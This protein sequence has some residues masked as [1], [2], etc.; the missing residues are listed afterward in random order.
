ML[1]VG[2]GRSQ[3][4]IP[5]MAIDQ[6]YNQALSAMHGEAPRLAILLASPT[7]YDQT[8]L[9]MQMKLR[10]PD[11]AVVGCSTSGEI[12]HLGVADNSVVM[13][14]MGGDEELKFVTAR[15]ENMSEDAYAC[16]KQFAD[17][18]LQLG[19]SPPKAVLLFPDGLAG[20]GAQLMC[21]V[22]ETLGQD[23]L[24]AGGSAGDDF[25][26]KQTYQYLNN[27]LLTNSVVG[28]G[29]YGN[30]QF[31][32]GVRHGWMPIGIPRTVTKSKDNIVYELD[33]KPAI[34][35]YNDQFGEETIIIPGEPFAKLAITYPLGIE[36]DGHQEFLIRDPL[37]V[38]DEGGIKCA[39]EIQ[40][41]SQVYVMI[42]GAV[43][44]INAAELAAN[45]AKARLGNKTPKAAVLFNCIARK[46][47]LL[48][49]KHEELDK[50][51]FVLGDVP[52]IGFYTYGEQASTGFSEAVGCSF[53]NETDVIFLIAE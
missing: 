10:L 47:I 26:F 20:N 22:T 37:E 7:R 29:I 15:G 8:R 52:L 16:G 48:D 2:V 33:G 44:A 3:D 38:T 14:L 17:R 32:L 27:E 46:K 5:E 9:L 43:E 49:R 45:Q 34:E 19:E 1:E 24:V 28:V 42:G 4:T 25:E 39:A 30:F 18:L 6:A 21:G 51:K 36:L 53:H 31:G 12:S 23:T 41:G 13:M 40:E 35:I 11:A 50:I